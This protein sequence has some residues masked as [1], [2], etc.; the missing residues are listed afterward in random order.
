MFDPERAKLA[1]VVAGEM[2]FIPHF[3]SLFS[4]RNGY[5]QL[6]PRG[7]RALPRACPT[8]P[9]ITTHVPLESSA[10]ESVLAPRRATSVG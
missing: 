8:Q 10:W 1:T 7:S 2:L 9:I 4:S 6:V 3:L 5:S